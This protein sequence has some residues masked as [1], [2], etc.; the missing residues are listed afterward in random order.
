[1]GDDHNINMGYLVTLVAALSSGGVMSTLIP[2]NTTVP[3]NKQHEYTT[4]VDDQQQ[5]MIRVFEVG[6]SNRLRGASE[7]RP[8]RVTHPLILT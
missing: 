1:M 6:R 2:R 4:H 5:V 8:S 3:C 7:G